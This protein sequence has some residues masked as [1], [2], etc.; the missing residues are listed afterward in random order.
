M[1]SLEVEAVHRRDEP[2]ELR[3]PDPRE[4]ASLQSRDHGLMDARRALDI[5]LRP[6]ERDPATLHR[7]AENVPAA[8]DV[9]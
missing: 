3:E 4:D 2:G 1:W 6:A 7:G 8:L 9:R 5:P